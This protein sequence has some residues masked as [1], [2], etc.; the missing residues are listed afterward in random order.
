MW[1]EGCGGKGFGGGVSVRGVGGGVSVRGM[2]GGVWGQGCGLRR[3]DEGC[4]GR[5]VGWDRARPGPTH[6]DVPV[7]YFQNLSL[8]STA[9]SPSSRRSTVASQS[10]AAS[11]ATQSTSVTTLI[12]STFGR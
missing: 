7:L 9:V 5:D 2:G 11:N 12:W 1:V 10:P 4:G 8:T 6:C 3:V